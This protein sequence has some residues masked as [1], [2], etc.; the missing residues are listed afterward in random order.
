MSTFKAFFPVAAPVESQRAVSKRW[1]DEHGEP[2]KFRARAID[3]AENARIRKASTKIVNHRGERQE[4]RDTAQ[5]MNNLILACVTYPDLNDAELQQA[6]GVMTA[7]DLL[8]KMLLPGEY[9]ELAS[10]I[11]ELC[12][13]DEDLNDLVDEAKN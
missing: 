5:Y 7:G 4:Q 8:R 6:Y 13:F 9:G 2:L 10:W 12:G 1:R 11:T 3:E